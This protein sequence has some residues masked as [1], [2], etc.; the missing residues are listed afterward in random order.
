MSNQ[1]QEAVL[2]KANVHLIIEDAKPPSVT[3][4]VPSLGDAG[5]FLPQR[6]PDAAKKERNRLDWLAYL[7]GTFYASPHAAHTWAEAL[8]RTPLDGDHL[9]KTCVAR[10]LGPAIVLLHPTP[11]P[12]WAAA[13]PARRGPSL[14]DVRCSLFWP[15]H[16]FV[17][18]TPHP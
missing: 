16:F 6:P 3:W 7:E 10:F 13:H 2:E 18:P 9:W 14:K 17:H 15:R 5:S 12:K 11:H 4:S 8:R 1:L